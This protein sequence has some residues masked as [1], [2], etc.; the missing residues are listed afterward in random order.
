MSHVTATVMGGSSSYLT[1]SDPETGKACFKCQNT[2]HWN[3]SYVSRNSDTNWWILFLFN[4][5]W[6]KNRKKLVLNLK[7]LSTETSPMSHVIATVMGGSPSYL[8]GSDPKTE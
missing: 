1:V 7:I 8:T 2:E 5:K 3:L 6:P 4:R